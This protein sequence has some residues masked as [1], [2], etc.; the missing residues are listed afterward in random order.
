[1][2]WDQVRAEELT[3]RILKMI[4]PTV[5]K[6]IL[7]IGCGIGGSASYIS[8]QGCKE[9]VGTDLSETAIN[10]SQ[11]AFIAKPNFRFMAMDATHIDFADN[12]FDIVIAR[13]VI[14]HLPDPLACIIEV[15]RSLKPGGQFVVTSPN[16][17]SL[18]LRVNRMLGYQDFKCSFDH[19]K[20]FTFQEASDMLRGV[21]FDIE[22]SGGVFLQPYWG[23]PGI[24]QHVRHMTDNDPGMVELTRQLGEKVGAEYGFCFVISARKPSPL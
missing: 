24:D 18:H 7:E 20:E 11:Q 3:Q 1:M 10:H 23:I 8:E 19:I 4:S 17:D 9:Y 21:G 16:R 5:G 13:E 14:E 6:R 15:F 12:S 22:A 2:L